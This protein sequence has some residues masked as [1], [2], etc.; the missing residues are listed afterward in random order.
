MSYI[1]FSVYG[2][3]F[4]ELDLISFS[5]QGVPA[6]NAV[7]GDRRWRRGPTATAAATATDPRRQNGRRFGGD[8]ANAASA[9]TADPGSQLRWDNLCSG[10]KLPNNLRIG[11]TRSVN[12]LLL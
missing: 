7:Q 1:R 3:L 8:C 12:K 6:A 9:A 10:W 2:L 4:K 5:F 11:A